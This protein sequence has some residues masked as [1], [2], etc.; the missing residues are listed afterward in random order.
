MPIP[1]HIQQGMNQQAKEFAQYLLTKLRKEL[2]KKKYRNTDELLNS[3]ETSYQVSTSNDLPVIHLRFA[4]QGKYID[5]KK[6]NWTT[7]MP[8][9]KALVDWLDHTNLSK[10]R[11]V[12][13]YGSGSPFSRDKAIKRIA[14]AVAFR[15]K[16]RSTHRRKKWKQDNLGVALSYLN[17]LVA[18]KFAQYA[19]DSIA[20]PLN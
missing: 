19:V 14:W 17:H 11:T 16:F 3:L 10:F 1:D 20:D 6:L 5:I 18:E 13:G 2:S 15:K 4:M 8:P 12:P 9:V 7:K